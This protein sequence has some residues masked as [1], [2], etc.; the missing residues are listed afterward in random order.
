VGIEGQE[1]Q[2]KDIHNIVNKIKAENFPNFKKE[3]PFRYRKHP[4]H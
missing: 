4:G 3:C 1:V 2:A